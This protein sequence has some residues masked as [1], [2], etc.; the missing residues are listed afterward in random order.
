M[1]ILKPTTQFKKDLKLL[2]KRSSKNADLVIEF[3][4]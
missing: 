4:K 3:L 1:Y 2:T